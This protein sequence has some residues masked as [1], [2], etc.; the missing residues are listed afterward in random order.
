MTFLSAA[1][2]ER[3]AFQI[4]DPYAA[5]V[6]FLGWTGLRIGKRRPFGWGGWD[7]LARRVE[8]VEAATEVNGPTVP[9]IWCSP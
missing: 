5:L 3:L 1:E 4:A 2:L 7:L 9:T 8:V 6:R